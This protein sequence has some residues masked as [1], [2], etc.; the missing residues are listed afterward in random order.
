MEGEESTE[1]SEDEYTMLEDEA[2]VRGGGEE[3]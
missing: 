1:E 2:Y 3:K